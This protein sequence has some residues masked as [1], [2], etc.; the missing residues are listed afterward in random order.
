MIALRL[1]LDDRKVASEPLESKSTVARKPENSLRER[2][3]SRYQ[4]PKPEPASPPSNGSQPTESAAVRASAPP[5]NTTVLAY[6][7]GGYRTV[8]EKGEVAASGM[9]VTGRVLLS[10]LPPTALVDTNQFASPCA[11]LTTNQ[12]GNRDFKVSADGGLADVIVTLSSA[13]HKIMSDN[14]GASV[15][16]I[17]NC[18]IKP[19]VQALTV[20]QSLAVRSWDKQVHRLRMIVPGNSTRAN[21]ERTYTVKPGS[22]LLLA[23][24]EVV[25]NFIELRCSLHPWEAAYVSVF[26]DKRVTVTD[27]NGIYLLRVPSPGDYIV[28]ISHRGL[29][30]TNQIAQTVHVQSGQWTSVNFKI[31]PPPAPEAIAQA[32]TR[33]AEEKD[34]G[35]P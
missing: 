14:A 20:G 17:T 12:A 11:G 3:V 22:P 10:G 23:R 8:I 32:V 27:T 4:R 35:N 7:W 16:A 21:S 24:F 33:S 34:L 30:T 2:S 31:E 26:K 18:E 5:T 19:Y 28:Q 13:S 6:G 29:P 9:G 15:L 25:A 1:H